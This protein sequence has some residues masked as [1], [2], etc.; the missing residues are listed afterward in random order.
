[1]A[2]A[3]R[4]QG[5]HATGWVG[6]IITA[7]FFMMLAGIMHFIFG[8]AAVLSQ[9]WY[10]TADSTV[11]L[12]DAVTWGWSLMIG[13]ILMIIAAAMLYS[14]SMAGRV[15]GVVLFVSGL[16]ANIAMFSVAP[17]WSS[18]A[19]VLNLFVLYAIIAHGEEM[20]DL[21]EG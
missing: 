2:H 19:I 21:E 6:W 15:I 1:M 17:I 10:L 14:G 3:H 18:L 9:G 8:F 13:G 11:Y 5:T 12:F 20:K 16:V 7:S 4:A